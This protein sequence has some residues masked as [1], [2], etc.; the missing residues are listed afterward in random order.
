MNERGAEFY[1]R[2]TDWFLWIIISQRLDIGC[3]Q[4]VLM[5]S[6]KTSC[7]FPIQFLVFSVFRILY[8]RQDSGSPKIQMSRSAC[9]T[10]YHLWKKELHKHDQ[11]S[12]PWYN[13]FSLDYLENP[14][15]PKWAFN[16]G[17]RESGKRYSKIR[18]EKF[19]TPKELTL[20]MK[21]EES[22]HQTKNAGRPLLWPA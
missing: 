3:W 5:A 17:R 8:R 22:A 19:S 16:S 13:A 14:N 7:L 6:T 15:L 11:D 20:S 12:E 9:V 4:L 2:D 18:K 21:G 10:I 1:K